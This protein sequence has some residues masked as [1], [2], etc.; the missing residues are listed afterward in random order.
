MKNHWLRNMPK[1][2]Y[3]IAFK[4]DET[5]WSL[6]IF[7]EFDEAVKWYEKMVEQDENHPVVKGYNLLWHVL[8]E[9]IYHWYNVDDGKQV[10]GFLRETRI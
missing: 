8:S 5:W 6:L 2:T 4:K 7:S 9:D 10:E 3:Q 1:K